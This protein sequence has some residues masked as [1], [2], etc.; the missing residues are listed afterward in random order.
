[1][2]SGT[3]AEVA[4]EGSRERFTR[5]TGGST[6]GSTASPLVRLLLSNRPAIVVTG[7][8]GNFELGG[9]ALG[10]LGFPTYT[11]GGRSTTP[12]SINFFMQFRGRTGQHIY[13]KNGGYDRILEVL[14][15]G[16]TMAFLADQYAGEKGCWVNFFGRPAFGP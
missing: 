1:M 6:S 4:I 9:Y 14:A 16:G 3:R 12:I 10:V 11:V 8:F 13:P 2:L 5:R 7:H 15:Q